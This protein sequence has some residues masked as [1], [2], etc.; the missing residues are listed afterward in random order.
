VSTAAMKRGLALEPIVVD[1]LMANTRLELTKCGLFLHPDF[2]Q[3]GASPDA[4]CDDYVIEIKCPSTK[5][6]KKHYVDESGN[7]TAKVKAQVHLQMLLTKT[8]KAILCVAAHDFE[9]S[10]SIQIVYI[11][12]N[13]AY[14]DEIMAKAKSFWT[15][16]IFPKLIRHVTGFDCA[17][18]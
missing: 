7:P 9:V 1:V 3:F 12:Y 14:M 6:C 16:F 13:V 18:E 8:K 4:I 11:N 10:K 15:N 2:P 5:E 17:D